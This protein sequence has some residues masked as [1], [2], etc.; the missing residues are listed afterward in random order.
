LQNL[1]ANNSNLVF[2]GELYNHDLKHDFNKITSLVKKTKPTSEDIKESEKLV[3]YWVYDIVDINKTFEDRIKWVETN[4]LNKYDLTIK[5]VP[6]ALPSNQQQLDE[7]YEAYT[8]NGFEGQMIRI[9]AKYENKRSK[10][11]LKRKDFQDKEYTIL[12]VI[13]GEGNKTG[14]AG[15]MVFKSERG[16]TFNSNIKGS[17]EF[18]KALWENKEDLIGKQATIKFFN[19]TPDNQVPRFPYV[20]A[21]RD[22][23]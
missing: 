9:N 18:I 21:I 20:I 23:E 22:Y 13:E 8:E 12:D 16:I 11:L 15:A 1:F 19:L 10:T 17:R 5:T 2:D 14:M 7:L 6:T 3:E 4:L